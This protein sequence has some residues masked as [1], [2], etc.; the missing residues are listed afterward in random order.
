MTTAGVSI[1][2]DC[3]T[4]YDSFKMSNKES[5]SL[6]WMIFK[7]EGDREVV[8]EKTGDT[9]YASFVNELDEHEPRYGV[10][11]YTMETAGG[12]RT[13][14][15]FVFWTPPGCSVRNKLIYAATAEQLRH[16][17]GLGITLQGGRAD[18]DEEEVREKC[19]RFVR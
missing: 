1:N 10:Y 5:T 8:V 12:V 18:I 6:N 14:P 16:K 19:M 4:Q 17:L 15:V 9:D 11:S 13:K 2:D 3:V 7:I